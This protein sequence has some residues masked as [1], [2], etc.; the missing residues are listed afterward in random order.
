MLPSTLPG[1]TRTTLENLDST[2]A[3][4]FNDFE[5]SD[6][7]VKKSFGAN[8][9]MLLPTRADI[10]AQSSL[11]ET[12][13][14]LHPGRFFV[15]YRDDDLSDFEV[16]VRASCNLVGPKEAL[17]SEL[18]ALGFAREQIG[19]LAS[20]LRARF[21]PAVK[22][23]LY[24]H[25]LEDTNFDVIR[26]LTGLSERAYVD[27]RLSG[28]EKV[29]RLL[30]FVEQVVDIE[31]MRLAIWR[32]EIKR[33]LERRSFMNLFAGLSEIEVMLEV[34]TKG[35]FPGAAALMA[36]WILNQFQLE[37]S[38]LSGGA[39]ECIAPDGRI[40]RLI[41]S[42]SS[43]SQE[44]TLVGILLRFRHVQGQSKIVPFLKATRSNQLETTVHLDS[45]DARSTRELDDES[46]EGV[47]T[48]YFS[49]GESVKSYDLALHSA[50]ELENLRR[51]YTR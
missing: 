33:G 15:L 5:N 44:S 17:C 12:L 11:I 10:K 8:F 50:L 45:G 43:H 30:P 6:R 34:D 1:F 41:L 49:I 35:H 19:A 21:T 9:I 48:R 26:V 20:V 24:I 37:I 27:S 40:V 14:R 42:I 36:G 2:L 46:I 23:E 38:S 25:R 28:L 16:N 32:N 47:F 39:F 7:T 31:W 51:G 4:F 18:I 22:T 29:K 3:S 13:T